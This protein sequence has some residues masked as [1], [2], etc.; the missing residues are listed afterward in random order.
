MEIKCNVSAKNLTTYGGNGI[1]KEL[2]L[3]ESIDEIVDLYNQRD[4]IYILGG[5]SN[6]IILDGINDINVVSFK[7]I[8]NIEIC[9]D[10]VHVG[11]GAKLSRLMTTVREYG[12]GG[13]EFMMGVPASVGGLVKMN[14]GAFGHEIGVYIDKIMSLSADNKIVEIL[15]PYDF[16]Y[17]K[18]YDGVIL[19]VDFRLERV[20]IDKSIEREKEYKTLRLQRQPKG[21]SAGSV[22][23]N[24]GQGAGYYID[25][26]GLKGTRKGGAQISTI[27]GNFIVNMGGGSASDYLYLVSLAKEKVY[28]EFGIELTEEFKVLGEV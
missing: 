22:F 11:A 26:V 27:H 4:K 3:P 12:L 5:G 10:T 28:N 16:G 24:V 13:L 14:A 23:K 19:Q 20:A 8:N 2:Y 21:R 1:L 7:H 18:G 9:G 6:T 17:R 15:P 25:K